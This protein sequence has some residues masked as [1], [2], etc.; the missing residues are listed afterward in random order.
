MSTVVGAASA[1]GPHLIIGERRIP[2]VLPRLKDPRLKLSAVIVTLQILGQT[3]LEFKLSIAQILV[4]IGFCAL[5]DTTVTLWRQGV[6]A[7]P[8][9]ALLT[10]NSTAFILRTSGTEHGDWWTLNGIEW[11][12]LAV[13]VALLVKYFVRPDGRHR[14]N[15]SNV[16]LV[17]ALLVIGPVHVFP[18]YLWWGPL[19]AP[20]IAA[21]IVIAVGALWVLAAV[22]MLAMVLAF[23]ATFALLIAFL[24]MSGHSFVAIWSPGAI[25]GSSYWL[26][27]CT[28]PE[29]LIFVCFMASDPATAPK[30]PRARLSYGASI[31]VVSAA[32]IAL[33]PTEYGIKVAIL[34]SL[35][36]VCSIVPLIDSLS[37]RMSN[38]LV[39]PEVPV[40]K[41]GF[42]RWRACVFQPG[43]IAV[44]IIFVTALVGTATL[45]SNRD[46]V[47]IER[48][49][50][51]SRGAQ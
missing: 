35:T 34:A 47:F 29:L 24:A 15:P 7:W 2:L 40:A 27:I 36:I 14:F 23:L 1:T 12:L 39:G 44:V 16:G 17:W 9:S 6:V 10:G 21:L 5:V 31:A 33:Q 42:A 4:T 46:L 38:D 11:F 28:S 41:A 3:V 45:G 20:V 50:A 49:I 13:S 18:Q 51:G 22:R 48:G 32:L 37:R 43:R 8:A 26:H 25:S 19:E 30:L